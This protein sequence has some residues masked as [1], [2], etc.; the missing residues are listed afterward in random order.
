MKT[1]KEYKDLTIREFTKAADKY[2]TSHAGI[3]E[4][5]RDDYPYIS[6]E[7]EKEEYRDLLD[8]GC[9]T[10]PMISLLYEK[11]PS[12]H[13]TG[14]DIT[15]RM[16]EM[17]KSKELAGTEW[18]VGD[19]EN[20]PFEAGS[21]DVIICSNSFHHYPNPQD[22]FNSVERV[23]RPGGR[24]ILQDYTSY[25]P[26][27]WLMNHTEMP[28]ANLVGHGDVASHTVDEFR[29]FCEKAG[30]KVEKLEKAKKFRLHLVAR[31]PQDEIMPGDTRQYAGVDPEEKGEEGM[32]LQ[33]GD[34]QTTA[35]IPVA[36]KANETLRKNPRIRDEKAV[37][38]IEALKLDTRPY[39][40]FLSH[41]GVI[42][43][44]IMLD[45]QLK[46]IIKKHPDTVV[47]NLGAGFDNRFSRVDNGEILWFDLD[48]PDSIAARRKVF[49]ERDRVTMMEADILQDT[50]CA[51]I[52]KA[53]KGRK[54]RPVFIAEGLFMYFTL[55]QVREV[56]TMLK[57][58]FP[59][60]G[61]L[62]AEQNCKL[63]QG[64]E[65]HH[66]TCKNTNAH[67]LSGTDTA[68]ETADLVEGFR[69][70]G[71][72]SF[73]EEMK[74]YSIRAKIFAAVLPKINNRWATF[75]WG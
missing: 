58:H 14:I 20:L 53:L 33:L 6:Q 3:Y 73:N 62:I 36:I 28:L 56:L 72:H 59:R 68:Q 65:K 17:A 46:R 57:E 69:V 47:V 25:K 31:K 41:E 52:E 22:F 70:V 63:M 74:K 37:E 60:G 48:L 67:F 23:L 75:A 11:D 34:V 4:M 30:L 66:D 1:E 40:K 42:A 71:E 16:I 21:F 2:E 54:S 19:C 15:P 26:V 64:N 9:G 24:L 39:D 13:Y 61:T 12:K 29:G 18:V 51:E 55:D 35:L 8:C 5:C 7:L 50:W 49:P 32:E 38:I 27:V 10:G 44:T 43:R 45:K